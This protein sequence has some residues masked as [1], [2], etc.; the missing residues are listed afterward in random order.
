VEKENRSVV[1]SDVMQER[2][3]FIFQENKSIN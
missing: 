3:I 1:S 2:C